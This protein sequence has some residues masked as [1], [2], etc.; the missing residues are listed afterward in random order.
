MTL[1]TVVIDTPAL[2]ATSLIVAINS[3]LSVGCFFYDFTAPA[4]TPPM[5]YF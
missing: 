4:T 2:L 1:D 5:M 3:I